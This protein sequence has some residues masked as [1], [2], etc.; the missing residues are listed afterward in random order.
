LADKSS[1]PR[2]KSNGSRPSKLHGKAEERL[3][4]PKSSPPGGQPGGGRDRRCGRN[5][6][7]QFTAH[8]KGQRAEL[9][10]CK[11]VPVAADLD[12]DGEVTE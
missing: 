5:L 11:L 10:L 9:V 12:L 1:T 3:R 7:R 4:D 2:T 6:S 8:A